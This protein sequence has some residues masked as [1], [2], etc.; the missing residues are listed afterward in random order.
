MN[1]YVAQSTDPFYNLA[2]ENW[3]FRD[4]LNDTPILYL[5]QNDPCVVIGRAQNPWRECNINALNTVKVPVIRRQSGGG[6]VYHDLGNLN[7]TVIAPK[8]NYDKINNLNMIIEVLASIGVSAFPSDRNDILV[9]Y[10][11]DDYKIS[12]S[13]F[14]ETKD[15]AFHHG[16]LLINTQT[17]D[18]YQYL[19]HNIDKSLS[20]KGVHSKR[21]QVINLSQ[22]QANISPD[23]ILQAFLARFNQ[24][25]TYLPDNL[26]HP[27][28]TQEK[29]S[30]STWDW[31]FGKTLPFTQSISFQNQEVTLVID[32]GRI[33]QLI[34]L[35]TDLTQMST[36]IQAQQ[37]TYC[38]STFL[39]MLPDTFSAKEYKLCDQ[40]AKQIPLV[41]GV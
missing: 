2:V 15:K 13:A 29:L 38:K 17:Q 19:H 23:K 24:H 21:A 35:Q 22:I 10:Q 26:N 20:T 32:H 18:L 36:W 14:R 11:G 7:Y 25:I 39:S 3:L 9:E 16:T 8:T 28:I 34:S 33:S 31:R 1:V 41:R 40:L 4:M 6:T 30:I 12:G 37:P 5:W 27:M